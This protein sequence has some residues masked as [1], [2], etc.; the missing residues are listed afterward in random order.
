ATR[1]L[2]IDEVNGLKFDP[3]NEHDIVKSLNWVIENKEHVRKYK[4]LP[5][6]LWRRI[7]PYT[8]AK[9]LELAIKKV[10]H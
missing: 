8:Y 4:R 10:L 1:D 5:L 2:I 3:L 9:A 7:H 6:G